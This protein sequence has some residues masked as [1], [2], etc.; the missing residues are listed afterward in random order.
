[1]FGKQRRGSSLLEFT[2]VGIPIIFMLLS[3]F[4]VSRGMWIYHTLAYAVRQGTHYSSLHGKGCASPNTCQVTIGDITGVI[5]T[6]GLGLDPNAVTL[7]FTPASGSATSD[8][9]ANLLSNTTTWPPSSANVPGQHVTIAATYSFQTFLA[10]FWPGAGR[11]VMDSRAFTLG[12]SSTE[13][14]QF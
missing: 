4:E 8:T 2:L 13:P 11:A 1:M 5:K 6:A 7:T 3:L 14:I 10:M 9:M 12:A